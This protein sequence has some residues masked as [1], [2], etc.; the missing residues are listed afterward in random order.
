MLFPDMGTGLAAP[1]LDRGLLDVGRL[2]SFGNEGQ[3]HHSLY[4]VDVL[5]N[6]SATGEEDQEVLAVFAKA[7]P[8]VVDECGTGLSVLVVELHELLLLG[9]CVGGVDRFNLSRK[10]W[11]G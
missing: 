7:H 3:T 10:P 11:K 5:A 8:H 2:A 1:V 4:E 6:D 9:R